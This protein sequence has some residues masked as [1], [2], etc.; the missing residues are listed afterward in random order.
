MRKYSLNGTLIE[1][2]HTED[3]EYVAIGKGYGHR[4]LVLNFEVRLFVAGTASEETGWE[5]RPVGGR[6]GYSVM[7]DNEQEMLEQM[8]DD[9]YLAEEAL[10]GD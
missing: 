5:Y 6:W 7:F 9:Y 10:M 2:S 3:R 4:W 8:V 1:Y